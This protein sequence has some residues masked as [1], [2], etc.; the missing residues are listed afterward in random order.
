MGV[1]CESAAS[2][3]FPQINL[4]ILLFMQGSWEYEIINPRY[5]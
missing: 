4:H 5:Y 2:S 3:L 1:T